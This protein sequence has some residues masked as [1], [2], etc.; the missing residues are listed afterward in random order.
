MTGYVYVIRF[1]KDIEIYKIGKCGNFDA[2]FAELKT[3]NPFAIPIVLQR[4]KNMHRCE[5]HLHHIFDRQRESGEWF[6][7]SDDNLAYIRRF[8]DTNCP[9]NFKNNGGSG[10]DY[11]EHV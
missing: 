11:T 5:K 9:A 6:R 10:G 3:G 8:L 4:V 1:S 2:R 7:L